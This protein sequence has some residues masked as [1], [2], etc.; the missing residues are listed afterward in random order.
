MRIDWGR[1]WRWLPVGAAGVAAVWSLW[2]LSVPGSYFM[3]FLLSLSAWLVVLGTTV[4]L[5][6]I[7]LIGLPAPRLRTSVRLWPLLLVPVVAAVTIAVA[8]SAQGVVFDLH[9]SRLEALVAEAAEQPNRRVEDR[10]V[11]IYTVSY[12]A[13][14]QGCTLLA[15]ED[16]GAL[17]ASTGFAHCPGPRPKDATGDGYRYKPIDGPWY[18]YTLVW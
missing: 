6:V 4:A 15:L 1:A 8:G 9:R 12:T 10:W 13:G 5:A 17:F 2:A 7:G 14:D 3:A 16:A 18:E 11:G